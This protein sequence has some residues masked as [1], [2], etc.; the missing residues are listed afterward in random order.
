MSIFGVLSVRLFSTVAKLILGLIFTVMTEKQSSLALGFLYPLYLSISDTIFDL[1]VP[2][3]NVP[4]LRSCKLNPQLSKQCAWYSLCSYLCTKCCNA[5]YMSC[6]YVVF[7][8]ERLSSKVQVQLTTSFVFLRKCPPNSAILVP[9]QSNM[10]R[11]LV[12]DS[13]SVLFLGREI[14]TFLRSN[15]RLYQYW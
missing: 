2:I 4:L 6:S 3:I 13:T 7:S 15:A 12:Y 14:K 5:L 10:T 8:S 11:T 1:L 9:F